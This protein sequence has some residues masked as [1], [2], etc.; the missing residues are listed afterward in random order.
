[1]STIGKTAVLAV[2]AAALW[3]GAARGESLAFRHQATIYLDGKGQQ[4]RAPEGVACNDQGVVV[5]ADT[6]NARL[7]KYTTLEGAVSGGTEIKPDQLG[8]PQR[9][10]FD[11]KGNLLALDTRGRRLVRL[12]PNGAFLGAVELKGAPAGVTPVAFK[13]DGAGGI[14]VLDVA[15]ESV[16]VA[17]AAGA[18]TSKIALP[19]GIFTD[20]YVDGSGTVFAIEAV[21]ATLYSAPKGGAAFTALSKS[22]K[23]YMNFPTYLTASRGSFLV[24]DQNGHGL[25]M[26]GQ[27]GSYRG[28]QLGMGWVDGVVYYP[29]QI[30]VTASGEA[31]VADRGNNRVQLFRTR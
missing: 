15:S 19:P 18:V 9:I 5:V 31:A 11:P 20:L 8:V 3:A 29:R 24:I 30:C 2:L 26:V 1:M 23:E 28:R 22:L 13:L 25:V 17:D 16:L 14:Y 6:G 7:V 12:D 27:D 10:Q 21:T 4:L